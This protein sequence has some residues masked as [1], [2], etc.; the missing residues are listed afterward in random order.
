MKKI[1]RGA[2]L[3]LALILLSSYVTAQQS[4]PAVTVHIDAQPL[5]TALNAWASQTG[6]S[7]LVPFERAAQ[8][9]MAPKVE[10]TYTPEVALQILLASFD[11]RY[12]FVSARTVT[13]RP[14]KTNGSE[15]A[16]P[17]ADGADPAESAVRLAQ[18]DAADTESQ[19]DS[20]D[21]STRQNST[22]TAPEGSGPQR[23]EEIVVTARKREERL[24]DV[25]LSIAVVGS[26]EINQRGLV[27]ADDYL[28]GMPGVNQSDGPYGGTIVVRGIETSPSTM[29]NFAS[30]TTV[31]TYFGETPTTNSAGLTAGSNVDLKLV[32]IERVEVLRGPQGTAFGNASLG[33]AVR[34]IPVAPKLDRFEGKVGTNYS[35]TSG[36]GGDNYMLQ[37]VGNIPLIENKLAI[38]ATAYK[39]EDSGFYRNVAGSDSAFQAF[40]ASYG[41]QAYATN[42]DHVGATRFTG[43]RIAALFK[44]SDDLK[45]TLSYL[46]Q[47]TELDGQPFAGVE[48][49]E[50]AGKLG[51]YDQALWQVAPQQVVRGQKAGLLDSDID[52]A[53]A[54][55]E[56]RFGWANVL[57]T[58]SH[59][60]SGSTSVIP[61]AFGSPWSQR[62]PGRHRENSGEVRLTTQLDGAWNVL[63]GLYAEELKDRGYF[64]YYWYGSP[65]TNIFGTPTPFL[66]D[67]LDRRN[68]KQTAAFTEVSWKL[69][70]GFTLTGGVRAYNYARTGRITTTG[71]IFGDTDIPTTADASGTT[72]RANLSYK[73]D[74]NA[75]IYAGWSQGFRLGK[76][77]PGLPPGICDKNNDGI[78]D[79]TADVTIASTRVLGSDTV[80]SYEV[81]TKLTLLDRRLQIA[82]DI[83]QI[84]WAGV[85]FLVN[86]P[87]PAVG[88][89]GLTYNANA[90]GARSD[91]IEAQAQFYFNQAVR[92]DVGGSW[93]DPRLT[94]DAPSLNAVAG[95]R[96]PGSPK[97]NAN[98]GLQYA[99]SVGGH[100]A[101]VRVDSIYVGTFY[102]GLQQVSLAQAGGYVKADVTARVAIKT[103]SIG[104]FIHNVTDADEFTFRGSDSAGDHFG[105]R[106]RPRTVGVQLNCDF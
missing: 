38:R 74:D 47:K 103:L 83:Y 85:P 48:S 11:L 19:V 79:G 54:M 45:F 25:P 77:Q 44:A 43:G 9:K 58:F 14:S 34:T 16:K 10:G 66:G 30:G 84:N 68:L 76:P 23:V 46:T 52:I 73:L 17:I 2:R 100:E 92:L 71:P 87:P 62:G 93:I 41:A 1:L 99:F 55:M 80:N 35:V 88:G 21:H 36:T 24:Q 51:T 39:Y 102:G 50:S 53:N 4:S 57:A 49:L 29:Q 105:T 61:L 63:A 106:L 82:A 72:F 60:E 81:G 90:G 98:L 7:V 20:R 42:Q 37:A 5:D 40:S 15:S 8:G 32:D 86:A 6:Y 89:C 70:Q 65:E 94:Q 97:V 95:D 28:R 13:I 64:D 101:Y 27:S 96:L 3:G 59:L 69:P 12:E 91:G 67:Y 56:Y 75:V 18:A 22:R 31:A 78:V 104:L 26:D 33:G